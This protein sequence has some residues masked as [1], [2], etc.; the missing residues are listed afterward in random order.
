MNKVKHLA[1]K[2]VGHIDKFRVA[3]MNFKYKNDTDTQTQQLLKQGYRIL[4]RDGEKIAI[5]GSDEIKCE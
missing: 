4:F 3:G 1:N 2:R 5:K